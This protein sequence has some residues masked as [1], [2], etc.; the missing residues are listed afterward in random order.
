MDGLANQEGQL[1]GV[2]A[3]CWDSHGSGPVVVEMAQLVGHLLHVVWGQECGVIHNVEIGW[4]SRSLGHTL[5]D[6]VEVVVLL[7]DNGGVNDG[8]RAWVLESTVGSGRSEE[9]GINAFGDHNDSH[10]RV[11]VG[12]LLESVLDLW[13]FEKVD[14]CQLSFANSITVHNDTSGQFLVKIQ[15]KENMLS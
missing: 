5:G 10:L 3:W 14:S 7:L 13:D 15:V 1:V 11:K 9:T 12:E 6:Q 8:T 2:L 4:G